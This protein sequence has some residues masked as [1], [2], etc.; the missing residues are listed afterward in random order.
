MAR[1]G[2]SEPPALPA[3]RWSF[4]WKM[5]L[6]TTVLLMAFV[7][8]ALIFALILIDLGDLT[9]AEASLN[10]IEIILPLLAGM[11]A[12]LIFA[13]DDE[14]ILELMLSSPR[15]IE[16]VLYERLI[17][18]AALQLGIG[19]IGSA[20][21]AAQHSGEPFL[22]HVVRW[23]APTVAMIGICLWASVWGRRTSYGVL[24]AVVLCAGMAIANDVLLIRFP[25]LWTIIFYV[26]PRDL[27][28][29]RYLMNRLILILIGAALTGL[30][31]YRLRDSEKMLGTGEKRA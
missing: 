30:V 8:A 27:P 18:L 5:S 10:G 2:H 13:P 14:P 7:G 20:I 25:D 29:E 1:T 24:M 9:I 31:F 4:A 22:Q 11:S 26:Q 28:A 6:R 3:R 15:P 17:V 21:V 16:W 23:L 19:L 12:A